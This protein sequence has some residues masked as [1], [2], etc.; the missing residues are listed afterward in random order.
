[1]SEIYLVMMPQISFILVYWMIYAL[2]D[3]DPPVVQFD[4]KTLPVLAKRQEPINR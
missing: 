3:D 1:M 4:T 2:A